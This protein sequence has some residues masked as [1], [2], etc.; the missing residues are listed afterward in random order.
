MAGRAVGRRG[1]AN[2]RGG[3]GTAFRR[4]E[5]S[6]GSRD[7]ALETWAPD[8]RG[9]AGSVVTRPAGVGDYSWIG[10]KASLGE[11][12]EELVSCDV[13]ALDTEFH[14]ERTYFPQL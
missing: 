4:S 5:G 3:S 9:G 6:D 8:P 7:E 2:E 13:Y 14:R 1:G 11:L 12:V 10:D